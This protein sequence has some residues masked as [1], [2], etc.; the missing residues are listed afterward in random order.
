MRLLLTVL[1]LLAFTQASLGVLVDGFCYL[2]GQSD[3]LGTKVK[4]IAVSP[5]AVTDSTYTETSGYFSLSDLHGGIYD[6]EYMHSGFDTL[7]LEDQMLLSNTTLPPVTLT[8]PWIPLS[9]SLNGV[10][11]PGSYRIIGDIWV[12]SSLRIQPATIFRFDGPYSFS[13]YGRLLAEGTESD[14]IF[15]TT[16]TLSNPNR[17]RGLRFWNAGNSG[18]RLAYCL[19]EKGYATGGWPGY[20]GGGVYFYCS[21]AT[22]TNCTISG[23]SATGGGGV[24]CEYSSPTFTNCNISGNTA[25]NWGGGVVSLV[26]YLSSS[27]TFSNCT[28]SDN[29]AGWYGGGVYCSDNSSPI[30]TNCTVSGNAA[31]SGGGVYCYQ[32]S[33]RFNSTIIAFSTYGAG[34]QFNGSAGSQILY[35][36]FFG[37]SGGAFGGS[38]PVGLGQLVTTNAN[39]DSCDTYYNILLAPMFVNTAAG[40]Y[41]LLANS[42]CINAGDPSLPLDPDHTTADIGAF[43]YDHGCRPPSPFHLL[44]PQW[45]DTCWTLNTMLVWQ[46]ALDTNMN[47]IV[48]YEVWLDTLAGLSTAWQVASGLSDTVFPLAGLSDDHAYYW[49]VHASDLN[50]LGTWA[51][52]TFVFHSYFC[53]LPSTF[54]LLE[55]PD[56][57]QLPFGEVIF[58]WQVARDPDPGDAATYSVHFATTDTSFSY[59][60]GQDTCRAVDIGA[61]GL[62]DTLV[63]EWWV[64]A[65]FACP[66][67]TVESTSRF[68]FYPPSGVSGEEVALPK[69]FA[70]HQNYPNPFNPTTT[71]H[72]DVKQTGSI[73]LRVYDLLGRE[74]ATLVHGTIPAGF[75]SISW[76]ATYLPSGVYLCRME[77]S[78]FV[79]TRKMVLLK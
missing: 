75:Q 25:T 46:A 44:A 28:L 34:I 24:A 38:G 45:G 55:P 18:S 3:Y 16:D 10:L 51:I 68:H 71:I 14:S 20:I 29:S 43:F 35:C 77:A 13:I 61:L 37:N 76:D 58:R 79:Q 5:S 78:G 47:D 49:T 56:S 36:D 4:F 6:V 19:I 11:S 7:I 64:S 70:L 12:N 2:E 74:V 63:V 73:H 42:P 67:T 9:G 22:F 27:P 15:F 1:L 23:N 52:D 31:T 57:S 26:S 8:H 32:S 62:G 33:P 72:Y 40:D 69:E 59:T 30:F 21:S 53:E 66:D 50:T 17:W 48:T 65:R 54:I 39:G 60:A 41:H